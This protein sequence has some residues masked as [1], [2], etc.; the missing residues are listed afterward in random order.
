[1]KHFPVRIL[2]ILF[3]LMR[4]DFSIAQYN[5]LWIPDTL[6][7]S[8]FNLTVK[9][10]F[11]QVLPGQ[12]TIVGAINNQRTWGPTLIWNKGDSIIAH[13]TNATLDTTT[14]HWHGVHLP[15]IMDGGPHQTI[16]PNTT[17]HPSFLLKNN[18]ATLWYHPHLHMMTFEQMAMGIGGLII[19]RDSAEA[20]LNLP[21]KYGIDDIPLV[22]N[23]VRLDA[24]N[25]IVF[26]PYG[27]TMMVNF[28]LNAQYNIPAQ[29][30]RFRILNT[31]PERF[32]NLGFSDNRSFSVIG[33][34]GGLLNAPVSLTRKLLA[35]GER[36]EILVNCTG[37]AGTNFEL[38][39]FNSTLATDIPGWQPTN[40]ANATFRNDLGR[41]DFTA[42]R[43]D[44]VAPTA[45]P[46]TTIPTSLANNIFPNAA[47]ATVTRT[48]TMTNGGAN[49]PS[50][51]PGCFLLNST[52]FDLNRI[53][54]RPKLNAT[55][56]WEFTNTSNFSHPFHIHDVQFNVI[57]VNGNSPP[58][59]DRGWKD[60]IIVRKNATVRF[61][62]KFTDY[63]DT[64]HPYMYHCHMAPHEDDG[65]MGQFVIMPDCSPTL[66]SF[67]PNPLSSGALATINGKQLN[68][69][70]SVTFNSV[71]SIYNILSDT[72]ITATVPANATSGLIQVT[73]SCGTANSTSYSLVN[74]A[75]YTVR[76][77]IEGFYIAGG[78]MNNA[79][80]TH[81]DSVTVQFYTTDNT[82]SYAYS[83][84][85]TLS[86]GGNAVCNLPGSFIG[87]KYWICIKQR[88][89][90]ET[91][92]KQP[93]IISHNGSYSFKN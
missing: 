50:Y 11:R 12:Q 34:D 39:V 49:C 5:T 48:F 18:A 68:N 80:G 7:G 71:S 78:T 10:T 20:A 59:A 82:S 87:R 40:Y 76:F 46:V 28:T 8:T 93:V 65:M 89:S 17:W 24:S 52:A 30:V 90:M 13:V 72:I 35:P 1:M 44:V 9:D 23:D 73:N 54:L 42:I 77:F 45:N 81:A 86:T 69:A 55:E 63:T 47:A 53:D 6:S 92:S 31:C 56:I 83:G 57:T 37:Q 29:V 21:R 85:I 16:P 70:T 14:I 4:S 19:V 75:D 74:S 38:K 25:Q 66:T 32:Y 15:A 62:V 64:I 2:Y 61:A 79:T 22:L 88:N 26:S 36:L 84:N 91:W 41:R 27:D 58:Q 51:A 60:V 3:L 67:Q 33:S 43:F